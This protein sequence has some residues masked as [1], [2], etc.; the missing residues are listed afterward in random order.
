MAMPA[1]IGVITPYSGQVGKI[2]QEITDPD[3]A[4]RVQVSTV[5]AFQGSERDAIV[6]SFVRSNSA[7]NTGFLTFPEEGPRRLNVALTRARKRLTLIGDWET[8]RRTPAH[9]NEADD[10]SHVFC[11]LYAHLD[12]RG[13]F[14]ESSKATP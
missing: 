5:D 8:L 10:A 4:D 11:A 14:R 12:E 2:T 7:G 1:D 3:L 9:R 13:M 6:V